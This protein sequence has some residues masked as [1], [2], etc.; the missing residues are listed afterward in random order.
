MK[1]IVTLLPEIGLGGLLFLLWWAHP[2]AFANGDIWF[3]LIFAFIG[4]SPAR[5]IWEREFAYDYR[6]QD[7]P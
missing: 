5:L 4:M 7:D 2:D 3:L 1:I 6:H